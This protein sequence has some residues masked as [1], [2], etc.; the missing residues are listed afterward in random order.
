MAAGDITADRAEA[1]DKFGASFDGVDDSISFSLQSQISKSLPFSISLWANAMGTPAGEDQGLVYHTSNANDRVNIA[2]TT[3]GANLRCAIYNGVSY[4]AKSAE[5]FLLKLG[6]TFFILL[7]EVL[8][9]F[10]I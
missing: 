3:T 1:S 6:I 8:Q 5:H 4:I 10:F 2:L 9:E 7:M